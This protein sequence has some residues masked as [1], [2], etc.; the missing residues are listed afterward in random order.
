[1]HG[2]K[3]IDRFFERTARIR[4]KRQGRFQFQP[5]WI[6]NPKENPA[7]PPLISKPVLII[8]FRPCSFLQRHVPLREK[9]LTGQNQVFDAVIHRPPTGSRRR[10]KL[11]FG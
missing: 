2:K 4:H 6:L 8:T 9:S 5:G 7:L 10:M 11:S 3:P 1:M